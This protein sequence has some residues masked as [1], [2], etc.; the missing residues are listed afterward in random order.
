MKSTD[1]DGGQEVRTRSIA[2]TDVDRGDTEEQKH[3]A[4]AKFEHGLGS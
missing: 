1:V 4:V 3:D 2:V